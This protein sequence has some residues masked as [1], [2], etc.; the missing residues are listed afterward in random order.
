MT[1]ASITYRTGNDLDLE[2]VIELYQLSRLGERRPVHD[3]ACMAQMMEQANLIVTAWEGELL[4]GIA[5]TLTD[6]CYVAYLADLAVRES[7]QRSGIGKALI[8]RTQ[9][10]L[11]SGAK[12]VLLAAPAAEGYYPRIGFTRH[13]QAWILDQGDS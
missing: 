2:R 5:R 12:I 3:R 8:R 11:G 13:P 7:H 4:V 6:F 1:K 9:A 10:E